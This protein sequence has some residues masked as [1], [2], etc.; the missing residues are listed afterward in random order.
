LVREEIARLQAGDKLESEVKLAKRL[1]VSVHTVR[2]AI[3]TFAHQGLVERR[4]G[5]GTTVCEKKSPQHIALWL[6]VDPQ[7]PYA[8]YG[9]RVLSRLRTELVNGGFRVKTYLAHAGLE[10]LPGD[11]A[12]QELLENLREHHVRG[13]IVASGAVGLEAW[14]LMEQTG[15]AVVSN[16]PAPSGGGYWVTSDGAGAIRAG[17]KHLL[18]HGCRRIAF[19]NWIAAR[20]ADPCLD[21]FRRSL[22]EC[23][24]ATRE[25]WMRGDLHPSLAGAGYAEFREIWSSR[26]EKPDGL[27]VFDDVLFADMVTAIFELGLKVPEQLRVVAH[28]NK[29]MVTSRFFPAARLE[30]D[31]DEQAQ[32]AAELMT[33]LARGEPVATPQVVLPYR[34][35]EPVRVP[36]VLAG[37][38]FVNR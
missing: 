3:T 7:Y 6:A 5:K 25:E 32:A 19:M 16:G 37:G 11:V 9:L 23:G 29:G 36:A 15:V 1:G 31:P 22:S 30:F 26:S 35:R 38:Q 14:H 34:W 18:D 33:R 13:F 12:Y 20:G 10:E 4:A 27:V 8:A 21:V 17:V 2:E 28:A 24:V